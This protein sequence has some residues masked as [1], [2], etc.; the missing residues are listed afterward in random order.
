MTRVT[1]CTVYN[2]WVGYPNSI[3]GIVIEGRIVLNIF[4][5]SLRFAAVICGF[6]SVA[7]S[8]Q[9]LCYV[10]DTLFIPIIS[11]M[12]KQEFLSKCSVT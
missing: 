5:I 7:L 6:F 10:S 4:L 8:F 2:G 9:S 1:I 3:L 11:S 12:L